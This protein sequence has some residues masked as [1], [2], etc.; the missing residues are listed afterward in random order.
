M[1]FGEYKHSFS[2]GIYKE[3]EFLGHRVYV[4]F[5]LASLSFPM[6]LYQFTSG[7]HPPRLCLHLVFLLVSAILG[8]APHWLFHLHF[9][10]ALNLFMCLFIVRYQFKSYPSFYWIVC[11]AY[12]YGVLHIFWIGV[13]R[14]TCKYKYFI[15]IRVLPFTQMMS[16]DGKK[17]LILIRSN[18]QIFYFI[19]GNLCS[20]FKKLLLTS[21][22]WKYSPTFTFT[23]MI[24]FKLML[25]YGGM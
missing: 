11:L 23:F 14:Q 22:S 16:F 19:F 13:L 21:K 4:Y 24:H 15:P 17:F 3:V 18:L 9:P 2:S 1:S 20:L 6:W 12:W 7:T 5:A 10:D 25:M 8:T